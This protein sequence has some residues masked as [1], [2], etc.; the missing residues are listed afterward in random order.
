MLDGAI[1]ASYREIWEVLPVIDFL[2]N[3]FEELEINAKTGKFNGYPG[4]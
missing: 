2:L 1:K 4:I 3:Y